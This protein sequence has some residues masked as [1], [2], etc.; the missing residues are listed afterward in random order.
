MGTLDS[1]AAS[2]TADSTSGS[3]Y[4]GREDDECVGERAEGDGDFLASLLSRICFSLFVNVAVDDW[5]AVDEEMSVLL[6]GTTDISGWCCAGADFDL[7]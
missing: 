5:T 1:A 7:R 6:S 4:C 3:M 2:S